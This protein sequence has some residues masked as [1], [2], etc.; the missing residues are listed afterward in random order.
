MSE[1][2]EDLSYRELVQSANTIV[3]RWDLEGRVTFLNDYGLEFFGFAADELIGRSVVGTIVPETETSGRDLVAM[4]DELLRHPDRF[5]NNENENMRRNGERVWVTWRNRVL[6]AENGRREMLSIGIDTT[7]RKRAEEA[8]R[9]SERRYR[10][11]FRSMPIAMVERDATL[12]KTFLDRLRTAGVDDIEGYLRERPDALDECLRMVRVT[13]MNAAAM[14]LLETSDMTQLDSFPTVADTGAF[15]RLA[16]SVV[17]DVASGALS[18]QEREGTLRTLR[19]HERRVL[20]RTIVMPSS[21]R[22][23]SPARPGA[24]PTEGGVRILTAVVDITERMRTEEALRASEER[25]RFLAEHDNLTGLYN[26]RY[27]YQ[28]LEDLMLQGAGPCSVLFMDLDRFKLVVDSHGHLNGSRAVQEVA[29]VIQQ[30]LAEPEFAV[31]YAG[32]EFVIVLPGCGK[33]RA[34][35]KAREIQSSVAEHDFLAHLG[36]PVR[37]TASIGAATCPEDGADMAELLGA[38]D[39]ALFA[40]KLAGRN[41]VAGSGRA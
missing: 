27:L 19:G 7:E 8:L 35:A 2:I 4:I 32:D 25:F 18:S 21:S 17:A 23:S 26:T 38:A 28:A 11:L 40:A 14:E 3:L 5:V 37:L 22:E 13:D 29:A 20:S 36:R 1:G 30:H 6:P 24:Q 33:T 10:A 16:R 9:D 15:I 34:L 41:R 12:L 31:A 39:Q